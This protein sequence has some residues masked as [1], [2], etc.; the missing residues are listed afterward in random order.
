VFSAPSIKG[1]R[2]IMPNRFQPGQRWVSEGE[3]ELGLG[4]IRGTSPRTVTVSF[5]AVG[6][7]RE[8]ALEGA[9]LQRVTF[10]AGDTIRRPDEATLTVT[11]VLTRNGLHYYVCGH[12]ELC[13]TELSGTLSFSGPLERFFAGRFDP[14]NVFDLRLSA[15]AHQHRRRQSE[16]RGFLGGRIE[17]LPH[18][19]SI[20]SDVTGRLLPRVL[21]ADEVGLGKTIE[22]CLILHRLLLTGR[23]SRVLILVPESLVHQWFLEL[24]RRFNL[25]FHIYDEARCRAIEQADPGTNPFLEGQLLLCDPSLFT[26]HPQRLQQ[27]LEAGWD[28]LIVD[29]AHHLGWSPGAVSPGY[30]VVEALGHQAPG[31]LL[32]TATPEQLGMASHF[33]RLRLLDPDRFYDL[34]TFL[35]ESEGYQAVARL[36][37]KVR[38]VHPLSS[39]E[40]EQLAHLLGEAESMVLGQLAQGNE[41]TRKAWIDALLDQHGT[42]RVMFRNTRATVAGFPK[43]VAHLHPLA[44][45]P[46][47][48]A[49]FMALAREWAADTD[50]E[51][52]VTFRPDFALDPRIDWL[53]ALLRRPGEDK[54]LLI[55]HSRRKA[56]AIEKALK[57]RI[58]IKMA[59]F[60][61][62]LSLIQRDRGAAW[63]ADANGARLLICSEIGSEGRNF[64]FAHHLV[65][66][67]LPL[68][69]AL[70]EQRM[71]RLD[72]IGQTHPIQVHVPF[73]P[74]SHQEVLARWYQEGLNAFADNLQGGRE[75]LER[76]DPQL[77]QLAAH[78]HETAGTFQAALEHL[79]EATRQAR[80]EVATDLEA[81]RDRLLEWN[82]HRPEQAERLV[83]EIRRQDGHPALDAFM[84]AILEHY[85]IEVEELAPR[86]YQLGSAGVLVDAFPGLT[87][88][89][90]TITC[91]R[92]R[93]L[94][95]EDVQF[96]T[97]DH[98]LVTGA[99]DLLLGSEQG[100]SSFAR[101]PDAKSSGLYLEAIYLLEC[102]APPQFHLDRFL[103]PTPIRVMVDHRGRDMGAALPQQALSRLL[104][105][106]EGHGWLERPD[107][108]EVTLPRLL[109]Q[110]RDLADQQVGAFVTQ[111]RQ[112]MKARLEQ[113]TARLRDLQKVNRSVRDEEI[114]ALVQQ[115]EA[116]DQYLGAARLRLDALRLIHRGPLRT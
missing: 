29:E 65:L 15:L 103:P 102:I 52:E 16:V 42:G 90:L 56:E 8:Y 36:A 12:E 19:L 31:L 2:I 10:R 47:D 71:G 25:W 66:F 113:E 49:R 100:N 115:Q 39:E 101:W 112:T 30:A 28:L 70:L 63:F 80:K 51:A 68:D 76:F 92:Q 45:S 57:Q 99:L 95:R 50:A 23:A 82:S 85:F 61:E 7:T 41:A 4:E 94:A 111:A 14:P 1:L 98:P 35:A 106:G 114:A 83:H 69:P 43:R 78:V 27:A 18:Q 22:A 24:L 88:D 21:L 81:G 37:E 87:S 104:K 72:R 107:I 58:T 86:T 59:V 67:D 3:P 62:G 108:R 17:L 54:L 110:T 38:A 55:C 74:G 6:E 84:L 60:H 75:L 97:W 9:P 26:G 20:A 77:R 44:I 53:A 116:L 11:S 40:V 109:E 105:N 46:G 96:L 93:A 32:L 73:V 48:S 79:L 33:A 13:E 89:G 64:Q 5:P 34:D 91:D